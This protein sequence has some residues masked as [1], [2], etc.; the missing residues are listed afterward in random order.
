VLTELK[1][2]LG[3]SRPI[4]HVFPDGSFNCP[5]CSAAVIA[6]KT[7]C[8][9][10]WCEAHPSMPAAEV[11][12][13]REAAAAKEAEEK[14]RREVAE[15]HRQHEENERKRRAEEY[16]VCRGCGIETTKEW[17]DRVKKYFT[18][19]TLWAEPGPVYVHCKS[20]RAVIRERERYARE[21]EKAAKRFYKLVAKGKI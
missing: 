16:A 13:R 4:K 8:Y 9:N 17:R 21:V 20:C 5:F 10:P 12:K 18:P 3:E 6:P 19:G 1:N 11:V 14:R 7:E 15:W 2:V